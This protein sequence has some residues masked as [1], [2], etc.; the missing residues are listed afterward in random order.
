MTFADVTRYGATLAPDV[1][2]AIRPGQIVA[3]TIIDG[4]LLVGSFPVQ[5]EIDVPD[6]AMAALEE[7]GDQLPKNANAR[8][9][10]V[11]N[12]V[13]RIHDKKFELHHTV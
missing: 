3:A 13:R 10:Q 8:R 11:L 9:R 4:A 1:H 5:H 12:L 7:L 2:L 6:R